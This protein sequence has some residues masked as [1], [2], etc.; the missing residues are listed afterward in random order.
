ME[1]AD[2]NA[3]LGEVIA[4]ESG[5]ER[6]N[7][8]RPAGRRNSGT[9][10][11]AVYQARAGEYGGQPRP[12]MAMAGSRSA[13]ASEASRAWFQVEDDGPGIKPEQREHLF[14]PFVRGDS[15]RSTSGTGLGLAIV[16]RI[17]DNHNGRLEIGSS[18][19]GGLLIRAW[20][21]VTGCWRR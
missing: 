12:A 14:Q 2:L 19:R 20:L 1:L 21:P 7:R 11:P 13:A 9:Y 17:I 15:A 10:A 5:Y 8:H 6:E 4:A 18:E 16:Q 3:V